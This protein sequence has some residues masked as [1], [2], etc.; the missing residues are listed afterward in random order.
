MTSTKNY[1]G[2]GNGLAIVK[3]I[4]EAM[5]GTVDFSSKLGEGSTFWFTIPLKITHEIE[6][7]E[8]NILTSAL[9]VDDNALNRK[10]A[11]A[12]LKK[13]CR[14]INIDTAENGSIAVTKAK[15]NNHDLILMDC[16]MPVKDGYEATN[17]IRLDQKDTV[18]LALTAS[19]ENEDLKRCFQV[20]MDDVISKPITFKIIKEKLNKFFID[21]CNSSE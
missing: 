15:G 11:T 17:E 13:Y 7:V 9:V 20:G 18:I 10:I 21:D 3:K 16:Q 19:T 14:D 4:V 2:L 8:K 5:H 6:K 12:L 1:K